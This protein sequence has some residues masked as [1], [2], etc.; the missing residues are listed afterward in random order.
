MDGAPFDQPVAGLEDA[1]TVAFDPEGITVFHKSPA[2]LSVR[3]GKMTGQAVY[4]IIINEQ[5]GSGQP[6]TAIPGAVI[7]VVHLLQF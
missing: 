7:T 5:G 2:D 3:N 1:G 4:I 6:V